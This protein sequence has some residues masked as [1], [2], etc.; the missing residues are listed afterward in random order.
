MGLFGKDFYRFFVAGFALG[1]ALVVATT[2]GVSPT[3]L[4]P[5][6]EAASS[7]AGAN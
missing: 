4:V 5:V 7:P 3:R 2:D 1:A 6:A